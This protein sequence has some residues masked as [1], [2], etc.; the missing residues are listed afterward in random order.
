MPTL[1]VPYVD[2][3]PTYHMAGKYKFN[4]MSSSVEWL[5]EEQ[6]MMILDAHQPK[7]FVFDGAFPYRGMLNAIKRTSSMRKVWMRRGMF[8]KRSRIPAVVNSLTLLFTPA[9][10][11]KK[12]GYNITQR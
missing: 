7:L 3:F 1:H 8:K 11:F 9:M 6:L 2:D 5:I 12:R 10:Q 4:D